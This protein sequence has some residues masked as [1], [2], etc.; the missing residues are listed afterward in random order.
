MIK[1]LIKNFYNLFIFLYELFF[2]KLRKKNSEISYHFMIKLFS[3]TGGISNDFISYFVKKPKS[4]SNNLLNDNINLKLNKKN[5]ISELRENGFCIVENFIDQGLIENIISQFKKKKGFY[6]NN[7]NQKKIYDHINPEYLKF[8]YEA[9]EI[10]NSQTLNGIIFDQNL[11]EISRQY[12]NAE[13]VLDLIAMWWSSKS[14]EASKEAAQWWHYD[15]D[16]PK[17]IKFFIYLTD[18]DEDNG[19]H[20]IVKKT[21]KNFSVPWVIRKKGY[22]RISDDMIINNYDQNDIV[23]IVAKKG[24]L[25]IED[26]RALHKGKKL[27]SGNRLMFQIQYANS[28]F[29]SQFNRFQIEQKDFRHIQNYKKHNYTYQLFDLI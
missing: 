20:C 29:G 9:K 7:K 1:V 17:W 23:E 28:L 3:L 21:H 8:E 26:S 16:R 12:L 6:L 22:T 18:C 4:F 27:L 15:M 5:I 14:T 2:F 24:T 19:P 10:L 11:A 25:L 13:P